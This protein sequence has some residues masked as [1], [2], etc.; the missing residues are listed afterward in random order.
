MLEINFG[1]FP[2]IETE[3]LM[4]RQIVEADV[5][6]IFMLRSDEEAMKYIDRPRT[7]TSEEALELINKFHDLYEKNE[8]ITWAICYREDAKLIGN[9][10]IWNFDKPNYRAELGYMLKP[11]FH[12]LGI[13]NEAMKPVI[14]YG[15][16]ELNL[17]SLQAN[18][19]PLNEASKSVLLKNN[20]V[21]E[22]YFKENYFYNDKFLDS[23]IF[24][25]VKPS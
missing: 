13:M 25:L 20:F 19:N 17:H 14:N 5:N 1:N 6:D 3:R 11:S 10:G 8:A 16:N 15:F 9:I 18:I 2:S 12:R 22:A 7:K 24:S 4:L 23:M 21:K